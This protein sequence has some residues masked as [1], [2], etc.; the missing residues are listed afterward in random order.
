MER[1]DFLIK[2]GIA[3]AA[4]A[5]APKTLLA[6]ESAEYSLAVPQGSVSDFK[7][8]K[9]ETANG[10]R[11]IVAVPSS[12]VCSKQIDIEIDAKTKTIKS[13]KFTGGCPGNAIGL[14][15]LI[16]GM[17]TADVITKLKGTPCA[18]RGTSCPDQLAQILASLK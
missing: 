12:K 5:V 15:S 9:D 13:C 10:V 17:K 6:N 18:K 8:T 16:K 11:T 2:S 14:C 7:V 3:V 1:R 4:A